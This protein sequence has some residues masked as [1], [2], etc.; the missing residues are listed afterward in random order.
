ME[1]FELPDDPNELRVLRE[2]EEPLIL[3]LDARADFKPILDDLVFC[4]EMEA[5]L[6]EW[7]DGV[8][9]M[10]QIRWE[11]RKEEEMRLR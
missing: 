5:Y 11:L 9:D 8:C 4:K 10:A 7:A 6:E 3:G 2:S 1:R